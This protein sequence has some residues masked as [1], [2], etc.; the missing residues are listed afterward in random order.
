MKK[1]SPDLFNEFVEQIGG[2]ESLSQSQ[3]SCHFVEYSLFISWKHFGKVSHE[4]IW[5]GSLLK[6]LE[7]FIAE[8]S[9]EYRWHYQCFNLKMKCLPSGTYF[10]SL[11]GDSNIVYFRTEIFQGENLF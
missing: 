8:F 5:V 6:V 10:A 3:S 11:L 7:Y 4:S 9:K 2:F 1:F